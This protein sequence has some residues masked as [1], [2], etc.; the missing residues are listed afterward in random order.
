MFRRGSFGKAISFPILFLRN[1]DELG[2]QLAY[3]SPYL[4]QILLLLFPFAFKITIHLTGDHL[5]VTIHNHTCYPRD[6]SEIQS[7][8]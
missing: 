6:F 3:S 8:Y 2:P 7:Y 1:L 5:G 4:L